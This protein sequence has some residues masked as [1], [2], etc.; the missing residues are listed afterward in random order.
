MHVAFYGTPRSEHLWFKRKEFQIY[1]VQTIYVNT[2]GPSSSCDMI[3]LHNNSH[4]G[5][6][7]VCM[8]IFTTA[9]R[10]KTIRQILNKNTSPYFH[11]VSRVIWPLSLMKRT[12]LASCPFRGFQ[13]TKEKPK[14]ETSISERS[15]REAKNPSAKWPGG[16]KSNAEYTVVSFQFNTNSILPVHPTLSR[17]LLQKFPVYRFLTARV[18][19]NLDTRPL[20][21]SLVTLPP[22]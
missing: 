15:I 6:I 14:A 18:H 12:I 20:K 4:G 8:R 1:S 22:F 3:I 7:R 9:L 5:I 11:S 10:N 19:I 21:T 17:S 2:G 13:R 16:H